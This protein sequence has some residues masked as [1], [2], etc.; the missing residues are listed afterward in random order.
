MLENLRAQC[1]GN[2]LK[3]TEYGYLISHTVRQLQPTVLVGSRSDRSPSQGVN[4]PAV[5][6]CE[7]CQLGHSRPRSPFLSIIAPHTSRVIC[8]LAIS[9]KLLPDLVYTPKFTF[10][11]SRPIDQLFNIVDCINEMSFSFSSSILNPS[12]STHA[13]WMY[14]LLGI[15]LYLALI[16]FLRYRRRDSFVRNKDGS[17]HYSTRESFASMSVEDATSIQRDLAMLEFPKTFSVSVFFALFKVRIYIEFMS[18][19]F[20]IDGNSPISPIYLSTCL[21]T[22][23]LTPSLVS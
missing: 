13:P 10:I 6:P 11:P 4:R 1:T 9:H 2:Q 12:I 14:W 5:N 3:D 18:E 17:A 19:H 7:S 22:Q 8:Y 16:R 23:P 21:L 20:C 15:T